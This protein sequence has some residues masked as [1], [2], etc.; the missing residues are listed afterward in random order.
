M[1]ELKRDLANIRD[2]IDTMDWLLEE[3]QNRP[4]NIK[5]YIKELKENV[6]QLDDH[7]KLH[8]KE[9]DILE[10]HALDREILNEIAEYY[11]VAHLNVPKQ[12]VIYEIL[13]KQSH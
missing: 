13:D 8:F 1:E 7:S 10:L 11:K 4:Y 12:T 5:N 9:Y 3:K 2:I 6:N